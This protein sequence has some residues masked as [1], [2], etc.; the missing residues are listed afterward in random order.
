MG[1]HMADDGPPSAGSESAGQPSD[2]GAETDLPAYQQQLPA[3]YLPPSRFGAGYTQPFADPQ[4]AAYSQPAAYAQ[5]ATHAQPPAYPQAALHPQG[6]QMAPMAGTL[7]P[8][9][10]PVPQ[11]PPRPSPFACVPRS[12]WIFDSAAIVGLIL[13]LILPWTAAGH[14]YS[15]PEV[16]AGVVLALC[17]IVLPYLSRT[18]LFGPSWTPGKLRVAKLLTAGPLALCAATYF[19]VDAILGGI[20]VGVTEFALAPGA[21]IATAAATLAALPR[22]SDLIDTATQRSAQLW[23]RILSAVCVALIACAML[24]VLLVLLNTYRSL[25]NVIS[26]RAMV[27]LPVVQTLLFGAWVV[28]VWRVANRAARGDAARRLALGAAGAGA[29]LWAILAGVGHFTFGT[30]ESLNLPFC[31]ITLTMVAALVALSPSLNPPAMQ[32]DTQ[33]WLGAVRIMFGLALVADIL[34]LAQVVVDV[35]LTGSLSAGVLSTAVCAGVAAVASDWARQRIDVNPAYS[36]TAVL[37]AA[38]IQGAA[39]IA[40][41]VILGLSWHSWEAAT[42]PLVIAAV[43]LPIAAAAF[44]TVP[45]SMRAFFPKPVRPQPVP[46]MPPMG[47]PPIGPV[48]ADPATVAA[49]PSTPPQVLYA[50]AQQNVAL[51]PYLA[52]NPATPP[53]LV[54]HLRLSPDPAVQA[55]LRV[56]YP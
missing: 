9:Y 55:A 24:A 14:G 50:L 22:R 53:D 2:G 4:S 49:D 33:T 26:L 25:L 46:P 52:A 39:G 51:W 21:W 54:Q 17:A 47:W 11:R 35:T 29:L 56:R 15:R 13:A 20:H 37:I 45:A 43:A 32:R 31:G 19:V 41:I 7:P 36:R 42:G 10:I 1:A 34:V 8:G 30:A 40:L 5:P 16:I 3:G 23:G 44:V 6:Y 12:D 27:F 18:N 48:F 28:A 38:G